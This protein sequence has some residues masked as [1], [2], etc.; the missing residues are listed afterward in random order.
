MSIHDLRIPTVFKSVS[1]WFT[2][3]SV[4]LNLDRNQSCVVI[5]TPYCG[6]TQ[7]DLDMYDGHHVND[8]DD[9][10]KT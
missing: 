2:L 9:S 7:R 6:I 5:Q 3:E 8:N 1:V 10:L 4:V